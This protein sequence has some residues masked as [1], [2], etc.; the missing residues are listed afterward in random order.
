M[1]EGDYNQCLKL[2]FGRRMMRNSEHS[3]DYPASQ[4]GSKRGSRAI[5]AVRLKRM[6]LD[7]IRL[8]RQPASIITTDLHSC[9]DR[10]VHTVGALSARKNGVQHEP[11]KMMID[12]LQQSTNTIRTAFGDSERSHNST[13]DRPYHGTGQGSGASPAIWFAI[14]IVLIESLLRENI[15]TF[16]TLAMSFK[17]LRIPAI[18]FVDDTDFIVT[19]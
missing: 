9:Y 4:F 6:S 18:L 10:I 19:G 1:L 11:I 17:L 16:L 13:P 8:T 14:T 7:I 2:I 5:E 15:G 12:T 3:P